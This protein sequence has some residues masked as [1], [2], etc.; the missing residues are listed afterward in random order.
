V[1]STI[2][3]V[4]VRSMWYGASIR[5]GEE[6]GA[7]ELTHCADPVFFLRAIDTF[8]LPHLNSDEAEEQ[9]VYV[10]A[11]GIFNSELVGALL[12]RRTPEAQQNGEMI[13]AGGMTSESLP[14]LDRLSCS[15]LPES[16]QAH[17]YENSRTYAH[18]ILL[19]PSPT[20]TGFHRI[21]LT[22]IPGSSSSPSSSSPSPS[23]SPSSLSNPPSPLLTST[24]APANPSS[25]PAAPVP[26]TPSPS[27]GPHLKIRII[28][29]NNTPHLDG[30]K[31]QGE[32]IGSSAYDAKQ[33]K[34]RDFFSGGGST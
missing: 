4:R 5:E 22:P 33:Q 12:R 10:V 14:L 31:R 25:I 28:S 29:L 24:T 1:S 27:A 9:H 16:L 23:T 2:F 21:H 26:T 6:E 8:L 11:H 13:R 17:S 3:R 15:A 20:D 19:N 34:L 32:G 30:L 18:P 7:K